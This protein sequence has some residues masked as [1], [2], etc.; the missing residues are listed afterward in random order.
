MNEWRNTFFFFFLSPVN[1]KVPPG[2]GLWVFFLQIFANILSL[3]KSAERRLVGVGRGA[4]SC[5][6]LFFP[7][8]IW[9]CPC[10]PGL[11]L[12]WM[13]SS[14]HAAV[15]G[16][17]LPWWVECCPGDCSWENLNRAEDSWLCL[18]VLFRGTGSCQL[19]WIYYKYVLFTA[20]ANSWV[21]FCR[22]IFFPQSE[23]CRVEHTSV[24]GGFVVPQAVWQKEGSDVPSCQARAPGT[25]CSRA[26]CPKAGRFYIRVNTSL[27][28]SLLLFPSFWAV[29]AVE[30][31][32]PFFAQSRSQGLSLI[33]SCFGT[34]ELLRVPHL[35]HPFS[36]SRV[37][38]SDW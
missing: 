31:S 34:W 1:A 28:I 8:K 4:G 6:V 36:P 11:C 30:S 14:P 37:I 13:C 19:P 38:F 29:G 20:A 7:I 32:L 23:G 5:S 33:F 12:G 22:V 9:Q 3:P 21:C 17:V 10:A 2:R 16:D 24:S 25:N 26:L 27:W 15:Q 18:F 35:S